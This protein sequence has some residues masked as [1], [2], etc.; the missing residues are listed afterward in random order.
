MAIRSLAR[1]IST[2]WRSAAAGAPTSASDPSWAGPSTCRPSASS[3]PGNF[4][5]P[6]LDTVVF[7]TDPPF[8]SSLGTW[9]QRLQRE[10]SVYVLMDVY[11]DVA[12]RGGVLR[13]TGWI[14]RA[15]SRLAPCPMA[16]G[17]AAVVLAGFWG[18]CLLCPEERKSLPTIN[19]SDPNIALY[20]SGM[21]LKDYVIA[22]VFINTSADCMGGSLRV[23]RGVTR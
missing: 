7:L 12:I 21:R 18:R 1:N 13:E 17:D 11:P 5:S 15:L 4:C 10:R 16:K 23:G 8:F 14:A 9:M 6:P 22:T 2:A 3:P 20:Y 19:S